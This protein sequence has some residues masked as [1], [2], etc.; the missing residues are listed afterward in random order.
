MRVMLQITRCVHRV[1]LDDPSRIRTAEN[2]IQSPARAACLS[3]CSRRSHETKAFRSLLVDRLRQ[4]GRDNVRVEH[5]VPRSEP[6]G[7]RHRQQRVFSY[8]GCPSNVLTVGAPTVTVHV[9]SRIK[10]STS[11]HN[12]KSVLLMRMRSRA[13][14]VIAATTAAGPEPSEWRLRESCRPSALEPR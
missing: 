10:V 7:G 5:R 3:M 9:L 1:E 6:A 8:T 2:D 11:P 14:T 4:C 12:R 13:A